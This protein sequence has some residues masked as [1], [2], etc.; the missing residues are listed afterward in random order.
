M[1]GNVCQELYKVLAKS[2]STHGNTTMSGGGKENLNTH[3]TST[4]TTKGTSLIG[5]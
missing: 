2:A 5:M 4:I 1:S 3:T